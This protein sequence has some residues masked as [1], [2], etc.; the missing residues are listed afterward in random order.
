MTP[1]KSKVL[2]LVAEAFGAA[3]EG[4]S[5]AFSSNEITSLTELCFNRGGGGENDDPCTEN[6]S[7][8]LAS[9]IRYAWS[10]CLD[11]KLPEMM[12]GDEKFPL[13]N[14]IKS[15]T[16]Y[17]LPLKVCPPQPSGSIKRVAARTR[18][19]QGPFISEDEMSFKIKMGI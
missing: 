7:I 14:N 12:S 11:K 16:A 8:S 9:A 6:T 19:K 13:K 2:I 1:S 4:D 18:T 5:A 10:R 17:K 3:V 15:T